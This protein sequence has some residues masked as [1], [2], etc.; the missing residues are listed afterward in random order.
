[1][2][3]HAS[4]KSEFDIKTE[5]LETEEVLANVFGK[6][7]SHELLAAVVES[8]GAISTSVVHSWP[9]EFSVV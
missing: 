9:Q 2:E 1:M 8:I 7:S 5:R 3:R 4:S 6:V